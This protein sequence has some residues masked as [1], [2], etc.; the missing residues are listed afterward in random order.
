MSSGSEYPF[1][2]LLVGDA[3]VGKTSLLMRFCENSFFVENPATRAPHVK[4]RIVPWGKKSVRFDVVDTCGQEVFKTISRSIYHNVDAVIVVYDPKNPK[5]FEDIHA[6]IRETN[7]FANLP[8]CKKFL[9][10]NKSDLSEYN[11]ESGEKLAKE[12]GLPFFRTSAKIDSNVHDMF[13]RVV[14]ALGPELYRDEDWNKFKVTGHA[15]TPALP[16][17]SFTGSSSSSSSGSGHPP[18]ATKKRGFCTIL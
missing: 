18:T 12:I 1:R 15:A 7:K 14:H 5:S 11:A 3:T 16:A 9:A 8:H 6:W 10:A 4:T 2:I 17:A 13:Q